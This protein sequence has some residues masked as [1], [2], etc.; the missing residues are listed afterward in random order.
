MPNRLSSYVLESKDELKKVAWPS[1]R[2]TVRNTIIVVVF[3]LV[4]AAFLGLADYGLNFVLQNF[5]IR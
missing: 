3:S 5:L 2:D 1:R 4:V